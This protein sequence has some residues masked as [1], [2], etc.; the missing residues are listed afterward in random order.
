ME[1]AKTRGGLPLLSLPSPSPLY[2]PSSS[3]LQPL[4][5]TLSVLPLSLPHPLLC[6]SPILL[7]LSMRWSPQN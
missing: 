5:V 1:R 6:Y 7:L 4:S 3:H 2:F